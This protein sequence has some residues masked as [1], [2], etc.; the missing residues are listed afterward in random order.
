MVLGTTRPA[1]IFAVTVAVSAAMGAST[2]CT[3]ECDCQG[4]GVDVI[5]RGPSP[6]DVATFTAS[7]ACGPIPTPLCDPKLCN[8]AAVEQRHVEWQVLLDSSTAGTCQIHVV[9][10][11]GQVFDDTVAITQGT[12]CCQGFFADHEVVFTAGSTLG[13]AG[14]HD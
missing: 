7:S 10:K 13:D 12:G 9:L 1:L 11:D 6:D 4:S 3:G 5:F 14:A 2:S 8:G